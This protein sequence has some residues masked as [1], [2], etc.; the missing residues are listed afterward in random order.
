MLSAQ[1]DPLHWGRGKTTKKEEEPEMRLV[2][3]L[4]LSAILTASAALP[5][6]ANVS[7]RDWELYGG[8]THQRI[9]A[10][11]TVHGEQVSESSGPGRR[12]RPG[13]RYWFHPQF[14]VG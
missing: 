5:A 14:A 13:R 4:V 8:L 12:G 1:G 7:P 6:L 10:A 11:A 2:K 9:T 3:A